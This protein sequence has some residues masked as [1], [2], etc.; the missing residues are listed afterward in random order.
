MELGV[1]DDFELPPEINQVFYR[2]AQEALNNIVKHARATRVVINI[3]CEPDEIEMS[4]VD[5]G[6]GFDPNEVLATSMGLSIM[7]ERAQGI[8]ATLTV[9]SEV[10]HGTQIICSLATTQVR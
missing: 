7:R 10:G 4:I 5:D 3:L 2:I 8:G 1:D 9:S 6:R